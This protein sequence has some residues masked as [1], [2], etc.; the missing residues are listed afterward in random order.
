M[1]TPGSLNITVLLVRTLEQLGGTT[2][3][4]PFEELTTYSLLLQTHYNPEWEWLIP[5]SQ[6]KTSINLTA[7]QPPV[8]GYL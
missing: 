7:E 5:Y 4:R 2:A 6:R 3:P 1:V 8:Y